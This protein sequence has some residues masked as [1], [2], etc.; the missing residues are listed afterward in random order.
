MRIDS[1][2]RKVIGEVSEV[3]V[4]SG[5]SLLAHFPAVYEASRYGLVRDAL[6]SKSELR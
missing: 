4:L 5:Y 2:N 3:S 1:A 6:L